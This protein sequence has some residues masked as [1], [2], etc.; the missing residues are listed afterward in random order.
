MGSEVLISSNVLWRAK[1]EKEKAPK[2]PRYQQHRYPENIISNYILIL[3]FRKIWI[4]KNDIYIIYYTYIISIIYR[5]IFLY[6]KI[7]FAFEIKKKP[8]I[9][10][11]Q[12]M[13]CINQREK[14]MNMGKEKLIS[15]S[16]NSGVRVD[17][18]Y[19]STWIFLAQSF[20]FDLYRSTSK[21]TVGYW[22]V[23]T[24]QVV[25]NEDKLW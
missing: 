2:I 15:T 24:Y 20:V 25:L 18:L 5:Y 12:L 8:M 6:K 13:L 21:Q 23:K 17:L 3:L 9:K 19:K 4:L 10:Y 16:M 14:S 22:L 7:S 1:K 11:I